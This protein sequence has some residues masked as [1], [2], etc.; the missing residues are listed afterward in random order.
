M[1][2]DKR[3]GIR[4]KNKKYIQF[5]SQHYTYYWPTVKCWD[6]CRRSGGLVQGTSTSII[7]RFMG[8]TWG[9]SGAD[10]SQVGSML[11][12]W[13]LLSGFEHCKLSVTKHRILRFAMRIR[14][15]LNGRWLTVTNIWI[16]LIVQCRMPIQINPSSLVRFISPENARC[17][18]NLK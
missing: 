8:P 18:G 16:Y 10:R 15:L 11:A 9:T 17:H 3:N 7:A 4:N 2:F 5:C 12:P 6:I 13:T 1:P 14:H